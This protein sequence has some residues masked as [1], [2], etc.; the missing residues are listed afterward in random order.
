MDD[1]KSKIMWAAQIGLDG[2]KKKKN[3]KLCGQG[4]GNMI[5]THYMKFSKK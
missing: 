2:Y 1:Q 5:K 3:K 4:K